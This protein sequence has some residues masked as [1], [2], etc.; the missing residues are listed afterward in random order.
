[1]SG[2]GRG[3]LR[4]SMAVGGSL[5]GA[6]Q[7]HRWLDFK[8]E[9]SRSRQMMYE[10]LVRKVDRLLEVQVVKVEQSSNPHITSDRLPCGDKF[11]PPTKP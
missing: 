7:F 2:Y 4:G 11:I 5:F 6:F 10:S 3:L 1:M 8:M 9:Q